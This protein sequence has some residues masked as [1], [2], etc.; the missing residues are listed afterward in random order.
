MNYIHS[1]LSII[2]PYFIRKSNQKSNLA[3][4]PDDGNKGFRFAALNLA[5]FHVRQGHK[6]EAMSAIKEAITMA[7]ESSDHTCLQHVLSL[8]H[9]IAD[10]KVK[11]TFYKNFD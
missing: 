4:C 3:L 9:R 10:D 6:A 8:L 1:L 2:H 11:L 7:Q 5:G